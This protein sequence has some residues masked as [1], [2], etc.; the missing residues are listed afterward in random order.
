MSVKL[1]KKVI[2][3]F[4]IL[5]ASFVYVDCL[6]NLE[7]IPFA[8]VVNNKNENLWLVFVLLIQ[9]HFIIYFLPNLIQDEHISSAA[10]Q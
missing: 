10:I 4:E 3:N 9:V 5:I 8:F 1:T 2:C 7:G 6:E